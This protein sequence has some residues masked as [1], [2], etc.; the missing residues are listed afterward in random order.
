MPIA[1]SCTCGRAMQIKDEFAGRK[2]R[3]PDCRGVVEVPEP[4][5]LNEELEVLNV[6]PPE[7][8]VDTKPSRASVTARPPRPVRDDEET[9][10][11]DE[12]RRR[13]ADDDEPPS[14]PERKRRPRPGIRR[15]A[16]SPRGGF[17][18]TNAGVAGGLLMM[19]IAV[20]WFVVGAMFDIWFIY[21]PILF[22][23]G[24]IAFI[25]GLSG[26]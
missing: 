15:E 21:P 7:A 14:R 12:P 4:H 9:V 22:I 26:R 24:L 23:L 10:V 8:D 16:P 2:V 11:R 3:C 25:K 17:G 5:V 6:A 13:P 1:V 19:I 18:T 20:V